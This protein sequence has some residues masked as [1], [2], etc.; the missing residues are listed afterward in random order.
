[1]SLDGF[2]AG[3]NDELDWSV[4]GA[5]SFS[6]MADEVV[7]TT[8]AF[9]VGGRMLKH[10]DGSGRGKPYG[11]AWTGPIFVLTHRD[12]ATSPDPSITFLSGDIKAAVETGLKAADGKNLVVTGRS[13]PRQCVE[14]G[15]VDEIVLHVVPVLLGDGIRFFESAGLSPVKLDMVAA[16]TGSI[17]E[18]RLR[19]RRDR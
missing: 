7:R 10:Y 11:G 8:G 9:M 13:V 19:T 14:A 15:L 12:P 1:M 18:L 17:V 5:T 16:H 6:E 4:G 3:P 2:I